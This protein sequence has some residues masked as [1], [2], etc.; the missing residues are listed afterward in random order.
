MSNRPY[1]IRQ[2]LRVRLRHRNTW[3]QRF[4]R[5]WGEVARAAGLAAGRGGPA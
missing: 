2:L 4:V 5:F 3:R 1:T